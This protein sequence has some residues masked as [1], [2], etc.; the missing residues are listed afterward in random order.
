MC[1][2]G[3]TDDDTRVDEC[4]TREPQIMTQERERVCVCVCVCVSQ[5]S[6]K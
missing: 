5:G 6:Y 3:V 1:H 2:K 4:V